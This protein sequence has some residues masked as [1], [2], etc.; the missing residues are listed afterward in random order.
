MELSR[1][2]SLSVK[3]ESYLIRVPYRISEDA[4]NSVCHIAAQHNLPVGEIVTLFLKQGLES[5]ISGQL[6]LTPHP[7]VIKMTLAEDVL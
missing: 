6:K 2:S 5:Y 4:D 3:W 7:K 1:R